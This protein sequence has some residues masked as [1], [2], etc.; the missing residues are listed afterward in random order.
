MYTSKRMRP[1]SKNNGSAK[2]RPNL[3]FYELAGHREQR[4]FEENLYEGRKKRKEQCEMTH[5]LVY[6]LNDLA[7]SIVLCKLNTFL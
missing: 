4:M 3:T 2:F 6:D 5:A 7:Y 1:I